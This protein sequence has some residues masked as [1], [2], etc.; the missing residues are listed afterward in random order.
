MEV[1]VLEKAKFKI[2][3]HSYYPDNGTAGKQKGDYISG[4]VRF[5]NQIQLQDAIKQLAEMWRD[6]NTKYPHCMIEGWIHRWDQSVR[7]GPK[8]ALFY[9]NNF[10]KFKPG[11]KKPNDVF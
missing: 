8:D 4:T 11:A 10:N 5:T 6:Q 3:M 9:D 7:P 2:C 1:D